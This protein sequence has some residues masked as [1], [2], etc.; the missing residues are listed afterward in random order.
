MRGRRRVAGEIL[1]AF[2]RVAV[3]KMRRFPFPSQASAQQ[4]SVIELFRRVSHLTMPVFNLHAILG[5][6]DS[7]ETVTADRSLFRNEAFPKIIRVAVT[8]IERV[9]VGPVLY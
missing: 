2:F 9:R 7:L 6:M 4:V 5:R 1:I 8:R 3:L